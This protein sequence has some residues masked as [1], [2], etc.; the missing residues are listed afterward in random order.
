MTAAERAHVRRLLGDRGAWT[1]V[2][3]LLA[4]EADVNWDG[5]AGGGNERGD[6]CGSES[7]PDLGDDFLNARARAAVAQRREQAVRA[8]AAEA[9]ARAR[10][11]QQRVADRAAAEALAAVGGIG[12]LADRVARQEVP[13]AF[14]CPITYERTSH[15]TQLFDSVSLSSDSNSYFALR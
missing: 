1:V 8:A 15:G 12:A 10:V 3:E 6:G 13:Q 2:S 4:D 9:A 5:P 11:E 7:E 14:I